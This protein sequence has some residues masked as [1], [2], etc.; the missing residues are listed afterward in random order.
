MNTI[1][2]LLEKIES[3]K[4]LDFGTIFNES[5]ELFKKTW[6][7]GFLLQLFTIIIMM[8][9]II[10][11][12]LPL[13]GMII[14]Q[15]ESGYS[16]PEAFSGLFAGMSILYVLFVIVGIFVLGALTVALNAAF[17][18]IM[19]KLDYNQAVTTSDFF[20][21]VKGK[22]LSKIFVLMLA[23]FGIAILAALL[24]Y[25]PIFYV[26]IPLSYFSLIY[27]FNPELSVGE[28]VKT[29]FKLG[30]K[31]WLLTFGL[32]IVASILSQIVGFLLCG[33]GLLFTA[34]F[35]YHPIYLIYKNS[36]GFN[37]TDPIQEIGTLS[38]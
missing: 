21:F 20:Y 28:I 30:H 35:V 22:Y 27:A 6:L 17:F 25:L 10:I 8:P 31:K 36:I 4:A 2:S 1:N 26:M 32:M 34:S 14:A 33:I 13:I 18:R 5:I 24:C 9:V 19:Q 11:L 16:D 7:Q 3:A 37:D 29:S 12:Y 15:Q 23:S 38:E